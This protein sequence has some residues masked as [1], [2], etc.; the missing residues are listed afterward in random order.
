MFGSINTPIHL[1]STFAQKSPGV[2][3]D[4]FDYTRA[5]NPTVDALERALARLD[6]AKHG[7]MFSSGIAAISAMFSMLEKGDALVVGDDIYSGTHNLLH[8]VYKKFG[9]EVVTVD[10]GDPRWKEAVTDRVRL[11]FVETPTNPNLKVFDIADI[12]AFAKAKNAVSAIDNTFATSY[13]QSPILLG[14]DLV[15]HSCTKYISGHSDLMGGVVTTNCDR[16]NERLRFSL[17]S[18]GSCISPFDAYLFLR[19]IKTLKVRVVQHC[20]NARVVVDYL[21]AHPKVE[22]VLY[23]GLESHPGHQIAKK[24]M[25]DFGGMVSVCLKGGIDQT[26]ALLESVK[27]FRL[28]VSLGG[29]ESMIQCPALMTHRFVPP[30]Q[31][32]ALGIDDSLV[33]ISVGIEDPA[34]LLADLKQAFEKVKLG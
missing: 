7:V 21:Q 17:L 19:S 8:K 23:P 34:D 13:L 4:K 33:R 2:L 20:A 29:A 6:C 28:G 31:R 16:L 1:S 12:A 10:F 9:L 30:E 22:R 32:K 5:G 26:R 27:L 14:M 18:M 15:V 24:Q 3:Y 11:V 25:R